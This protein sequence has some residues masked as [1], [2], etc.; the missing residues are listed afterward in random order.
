MNMVLDRS[1]RAHAAGRT[2]SLKPCDHIHCVAVEVGTIIDGMSKVTR[3]AK[4]YGLGRRLLCIED[5]HLQLHPCGTVHRPVNAIKHDQQRLA[6][7]L[8]DFGAM[9]LDRWVD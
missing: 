6:T 1:V 9:L 7:A 3:D 5:L 4:P 2:P 8:D